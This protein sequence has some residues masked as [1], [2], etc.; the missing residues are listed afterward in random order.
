M[1]NQNRTTH[2][3]LLQHD[4]ASVAVFFLP[5]WQQK[6]APGTQAL[7]LLPDTIVWNGE[8]RFGLPF[9]LSVLEV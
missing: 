7:V 4:P 2:N 1:R 9:F 5:Q 3:L 8:W 6:L